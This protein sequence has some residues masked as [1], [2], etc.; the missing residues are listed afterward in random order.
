MKLLVSKSSPMLIPDTDFGL[1]GDSV[2]QL[3]IVSR[4]DNKPSSKIIS[5][6][7]D[8][9]ICATGLG[10]PVSYIYVSSSV[11]SSDPLVYL[12]RLKAQKI[13]VK[14]VRIT[15]STELIQFRNDNYVSS[16]GLPDFVFWNIL[17]PRFELVMSDGKHTRSSRSF[18]RRQCLRAIDEGLYVY[19]HDQIDKSVTELSRTDIDSD[20]IA[21]VWGKPSK[22]RTRRILISKH[23]L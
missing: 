4:L 17:Y 12:L 10:S 7:A 14:G 19:V 13:Y 15:T 3:S 21:D 9:D 20:T 1:I 2:K 23:N 5:S 18:W 22:F 11:R 16:L 6:Y 8:F